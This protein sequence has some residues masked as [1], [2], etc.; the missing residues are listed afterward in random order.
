MRGRG[1]N[2]YA[3]ETTIME[4]I[5]KLI[6]HIVRELVDVPEKVVVIPE[7]GPDAVVYRIH[8]EESDVGKALGKEGRIAKAMRTVVHA[9]G[10]KYGEKSH[11]EIV[12]TTERSP[13]HSPVASFAEPVE[14]KRVPALVP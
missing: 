11:L 13:L 9:V 14:P 5:R 7:P 8:V 12:G 4:E 2:D 6:E 1:R 3:L 10:R